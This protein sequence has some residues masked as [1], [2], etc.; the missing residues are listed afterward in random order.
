MGAGRRDRRVPQRELAVE[1][2]EVRFLGVM[3]FRKFSTDDVVVDDRPKKKR[4]RFHSPVIASAAAVGLIA[5]VTTMAVAPA[6][7]VQASLSRQGRTKIRIK[8]T[9]K[10]RAASAGCMLSG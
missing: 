9:A 2:I 3:P 4:N 5:P 6:A 7:A 1:N 8:V 10:I